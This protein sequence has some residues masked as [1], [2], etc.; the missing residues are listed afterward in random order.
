MMLNRP[1]YAAVVAL[2]MAAGPMATTAA[3]TATAVPAPLS[4]PEDRAAVASVESYLN[5]VQSMT[6]R[7]E[8]MAASTGEAAVGKLYLSRPGRM[9]LVYDPPSPVLIVADGSFLIYYDSKLEQ[10][11]YVGLD[12]TPAGIL[13][14]P[15]VVL[16]GD[17]TVTALH[18]LPGAVEIS[19][20][21]TEDPEAGELTMLLTENPMALRQWRVRDA[22]G[23]VVTVSLSDAHTDATLAPELFEFRNPNFSK[24]QRK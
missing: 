8:Q 14:R 1:F 2:V 16:G 4:T 6:A 15:H 12:S 11:S 23:Q 10:V 5:G 9:R 17:I 21:E 3:A 22:Q 24:Q 20:E 7:F 19:L 13:L 18:R